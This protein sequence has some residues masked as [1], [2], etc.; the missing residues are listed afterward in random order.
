MAPRPPSQL[1]AAVG[2]TIR[3][4]REERGWG[5]RELATRTG[6]AQPSVQRLEAGLLHV[7]VDHLSVLAGVLDVNACELLEMS[8]KANA[9]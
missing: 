5:Q 9:S 6:W 2:H 4:L 8:E 7:T 3:L 1:S